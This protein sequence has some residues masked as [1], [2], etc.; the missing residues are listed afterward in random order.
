MKISIN[1]NSKPIKKRPHNLEHKYKD[2]F[3]KE[4]NNV[5]IAGIIYFVDQVKWERP[6]VVKPK[7]HDS[8]ILQICVYFRELN[9]LMLRY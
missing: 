6:K 8:K 9:K 7:K 2:I 5:L 3:K 4:I 1:L